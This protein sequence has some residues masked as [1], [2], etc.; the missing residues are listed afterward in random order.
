MQKP[1]GGISSTSVWA[2]R[3]LRVWGRRHYRSFPWR[4]DPSLYHALVTEV[5]LQQTGADRVRNVRAVLL[6]RF[7]QPSDLAAAQPVDV[8]EIVAPLGLSKQRSNRLVALA[9]ALL[10]RRFVHRSVS[11]LTALPGIGGYG[12]S[13]VACF[14]W[15]RSEAVVDVNSARIVSRLFGIPIDGGEARRHP[16]VRARAN[17]LV[18]GRYPAAINYGLLDLGA[19]VCRPRP[20]CESCPLRKRCAFNRDRL[21]LVSSQRC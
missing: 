12:A 21:A 5:L 7:P 17:E 1:R 19:L 11:E 4:S 9:S 8:Q 16:D 13:A 14:I 18:S 2:R 20:N 10:E 3:Q 6:K 15:Q